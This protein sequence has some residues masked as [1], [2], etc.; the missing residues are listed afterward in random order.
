MTIE[1]KAKEL[2]NRYHREWRAKNP[3]KVRAR[4]KRY[5]EKKA[6]KA[7]QEEQATNA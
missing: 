3:E 5:W 4:N 6:A 1:E 7:L 2:R